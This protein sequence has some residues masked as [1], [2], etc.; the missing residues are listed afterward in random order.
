MADRDW[1]FR[2]WMAFSDKIQ[3]SL[4]NELGWSKRK[5]SEVWNGDQ[6][7]KRDTVNEVADWLGVDPFELLMPPLEAMRLRQLRQTA[8]AIAEQHPMAADQQRDFRHP[9]PPAT[10]D[11]KRRKRGAA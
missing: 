1:F 10:T 9:A 2:E 6:G 5:A 3:A 11:H 8:I 4:V 7:Y